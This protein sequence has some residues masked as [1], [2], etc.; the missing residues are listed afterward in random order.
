MK[1]ILVNATSLV[2]GGALS[3]LNQFISHVND[4]FYHIFISDEVDINQG[5]IVGSNIK[6]WRVKPQSSVARVIWDFFG[7]KKFARKNNLNYDLVISLQNTT[8]RTGGKPQIVYLH[9]GIPLHPKKWSFL[10]SS[11][12]K[13]AFYKY[14]YPFFIFINKDKDTKFIVQTEWMKKALIKKFKISEKN[15]YNIKPDF[16]RWNLGDYKM[17]KSS[18]KVFNIFYPATGEIFKNHELIL[19]ALKCLYE[20]KFDMKSIKVNFTFNDGE[21]SHISD[22]L[23][24]NPEIKNSIN[25]I[26][27]LSYVNVLMYYENSDLILFPSQIES[28]GLPL[29]E[30]AYAGRKIISLPT[31]FAKEVLFDYEGIEFVK[32]NPNDW[33]LAIKRSIEDYDIQ[34]PSFKPS[35]HNSWNTFFQLF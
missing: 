24:K 12:R 19:S 28:F 34:Y 31:D 21:Y 7:I 25:F 1:V 35:F 26:G 14:I 9:Q 18:D 5:F 13:Y 22:F 6:L 4:D 17:D 16:I 30:G 8:V 3:I 10:I 27:T 15:V 2:S 23:L 20:S 33:A 29:L 32:E 11:E